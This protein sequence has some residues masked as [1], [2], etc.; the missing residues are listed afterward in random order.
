MMS[1]FLMQACVAAGKWVAPAA[2]DTL[3]AALSEAP[4]VFAGTR[5]ALHG[6]PTFVKA[7]GHQLEYA[8]GQLLYVI[9]V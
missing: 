8:G 6:P 4:R 5:L 2:A 7:F 3:A 1:T 9:P